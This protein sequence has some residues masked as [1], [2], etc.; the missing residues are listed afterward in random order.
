[1]TQP[2]PHATNLAR[3]TRHTSVNSLTSNTCANNSSTTTTSAFNRGNNGNNI[4][5]TKTVAV[6]SVRMVCGQHITTAH[7][8]RRACLPNQHMQLYTNTTTHNQPT[9]RMPSQKLMHLCSQ[10]HDAML[11]AGHMPHMHTAC[12]VRPSACRLLPKEWYQEILCVEELPDEH[13]VVHKLIRLLQVYLPG[14][15]QQQAGERSV[16]RSHHHPAAHVC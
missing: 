4:S 11:L 9:A 5:T 15:P 12:T 13:V 1:M 2:S 10:D 16:P 8:C 3:D 14:P 6:S 7:S